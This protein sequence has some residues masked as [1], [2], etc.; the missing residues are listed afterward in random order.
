MSW[1]DRD[2]N[3]G[4]EAFNEFLMNPAS[5]RGMSLPVLQ[6]SSLTIRLNF[7][8]LLFLGLDLIGT[9]SQG[10]GFTRFAV[11]TGLLLAVLLWHEF[12][13]RVISQMV[14]GDHRE[15]VLW[16]LGG[17][18]PPYTSNRPWAMFWANI[19]GNL[20]TLPLAGLAL[21]AA[22]FLS[23]GTLNFS[24][25]SHFMFNVMSFYVPAGVTA[26]SAVS[27]LLMYS[28]LKLFVMCTSIFLINMFPAYWFD[29]GYIW[30]AALTP[31]AGPYQAI[32]ITCIAGMVLSIPFIFLTLWPRIDIFGLIVWVLIFS[33]CYKRRKM[34]VAAGPGVV[35]EELSGG[36]Y[37]YMNRGD[38]KPKKRKRGGW[39]LKNARKKAMQDQAEQE[40]ID[41]ILEKVKNH[42]LH[43]LTWWEKRTLR[44]ATE[45]QRQQDLVNK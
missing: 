33:S 20:F 31:K 42:G 14:G 1:R 34:L 38:D 40:K 2:Y 7:W 21:G 39:W 18:V 27:P 43:S 19:G 23:N 11:D 32:N 10:L 12:G 28:L 37:D 4:G 8:L 41:R 22:W 44:K 24:A 45:R 29:G 15:W 9:L 30:Q 26:E 16:P 36:S 35:E 25:L 17:M 5:I 3:R 6:S 13:H